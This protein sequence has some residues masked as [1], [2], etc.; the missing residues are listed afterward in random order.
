ML[1]HQDRTGITGVCFGCKH[2]SVFANAT[3]L[4]VAT[5]QV[6]SIAFSQSAPI[7][8]VFRLIAPA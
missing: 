8:E 2:I 7:D 6:L 4:I 3:L 1:Q 5:S